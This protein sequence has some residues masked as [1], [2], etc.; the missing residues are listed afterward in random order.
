[1]SQTSQWT[2]IVKHTGLCLNWRGLYIKMPFNA[3]LLNLGVAKEK[4][5][6]LFLFLF[7]IH[8][9]FERSGNSVDYLINKK[10]F[11]RLSF[12]IYR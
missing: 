6:D 9:E 10:H 5:T 2:Y 8:L 4:K 1:M 3:L 12:T 11:M 7:I